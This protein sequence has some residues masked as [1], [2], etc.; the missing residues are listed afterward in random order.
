MVVKTLWY[1]NKDRHIKERN[2]I[3]S[4]ETNPYIYN[5]LIFK[6]NAKSMGKEYSFQQIIVGKWIFTYK[7]K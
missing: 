3:V 6:K 5:Q 1:W 2:R 4:Q 7:K